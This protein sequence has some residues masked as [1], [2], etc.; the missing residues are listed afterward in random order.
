MSS[1]SEE[2]ALRAR[3]ERVVMEE[4]L[5]NAR[6][7]RL[8]GQQKKLQQRL[9]ELKAQEKAFLE[10]EE[11]YQIRVALDEDRLEQGM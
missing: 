5:L 3:E 2:E 9:Q 8:S 10:A 11:A 6:E 7:H 1:T 4:E